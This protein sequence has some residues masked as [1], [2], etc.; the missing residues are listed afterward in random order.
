M[1]QVRDDS[2]TAFEELVLR[3]Q[4]RLSAVLEHLV[5]SRDQAESTIDLRTRGL[6][7]PNPYAARARAR[8][9]VEEQ[10]AADD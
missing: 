8:R 5:G 1:L 3:Y 10:E 4:T 7:A 6:N 2:A 9:R